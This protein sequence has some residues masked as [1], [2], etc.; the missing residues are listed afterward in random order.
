MNRRLL[1]HS[2]RSQ[3]RTRFGRVGFLFF[4]KMNSTISRWLMRRSLVSLEWD[5]QRLG[6]TVL[7]KL[8]ERATRRW[9]DGSAGEIRYMPGVAIFSS[10]VSQCAITL[11]AV[12]APLA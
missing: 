9:G 12:D 7:G 10:L 4:T 11:T 2:G 1:A 8:V 3:S 6:Q 5:L